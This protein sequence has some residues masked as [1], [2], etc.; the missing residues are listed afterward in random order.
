MCTLLYLIAGSYCRFAYEI[1]C[2]SEVSRNKQSLLISSKMAELDDLDFLKAGCVHHFWKHELK[3]GRKLDLYRPCY[4]DK[5]IICV[6]ST[7]TK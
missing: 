7:R 1:Q 6:W 3:Y 5:D 4:Q 2:G